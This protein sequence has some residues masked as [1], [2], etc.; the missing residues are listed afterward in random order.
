MSRMWL[1]IIFKL[2][3][4]GLNSEFSF[5]LAGCHTKLKEHSLSHYLPITGGT[6]TK[7]LPFQ[8]VLAIRENSNNLRQDLNS[9]P[10]DR[11]Q[12]W[13]PLHQEALDLWPSQRPVKE[14]KVI[15]SNDSPNDNT[16]E[17][18]RNFEPRPSFNSRGS[19]TWTRVQV[20]SIPV[21]LPTCSQDWTWNLQM[22]VT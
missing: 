14:P 20:L 17:S 19:L 18:T 22:I 8:T 1:M 6:L 21:L 16:R 10:R 12:R 13:L 2:S 11:F 3:F 15:K 9:V 7:F 5:S 4:T